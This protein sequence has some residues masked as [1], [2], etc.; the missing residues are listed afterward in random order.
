MSR[1][2]S[3]SMR[4]IGKRFGRT[5]ALSGVDF[6]AA[7]GMINAVIGENGAGKTTLMKV[8]FGLVRPD[9]GAIELDGSPLPAG[10]SPRDSI[11]LGIGMLQQHFSQV[12][13]FS[14]LENI[15][16][17]NEPKRGVVLDADKARGELKKIIEELGTALPLD[18]P[19]SS[20]SVSERQIV[21]IARMRYTG[22]RLMIFDEP[23]ASLTPQEIERFY[24]LVTR[25]AREGA[26][27]ILITHRLGEVMRHAGRVT[28]LRRGRATGVFAREELDEHRLIEAIVPEADVSREGPVPQPFDA[29][30]PAVLS[31]RGIACGN[32]AGS[33]VLGE[34]DLDVRAREVVGIAGVTGGGQVPLAE[35][36]VGLREPL[37]GTV[38]LHG[39]DVTAMDTFARRRMGMVYIPEDRLTDGVIPPFSLV[40]NRLLGDQRDERYHAVTGYRMPLLRSDVESKIAAYD[41]AADDPEQSLATLSGGNQ[42]KLML[43]REL[44]RLPKVIVAHGPTRGLDV[45]ASRRCYEKLLR[46]AA[47]GAAVILFSTELNDLLA[48]A[49][50]ICV[51]YAGRMIDAGPSSE[52]DA[53]TVGLLMTRG[54]EAM[55]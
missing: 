20:L 48:Y 49:H 39:S 36:M 51:L 7:P 38:V 16:L 19:V 40:L 25:L 13:S 14:V 26:T 53:R 42:Q 31:L 30:G 11:R 44:D 45:V 17:G 52:L 12:A 47:G 8:L 33:R 37:E 6:D 3:V 41:I 29:E 23:T 28:V 54:T 32:A 2:P 18:A 1:G 34:I 50:R 5:E 21:E 4:S 35:T 22:A 46:L 43:A 24:E 10:H 15:V 55:A 9:S 27:I